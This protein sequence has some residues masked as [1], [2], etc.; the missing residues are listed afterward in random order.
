MIYKVRNGL[1]PIV[2]GYEFLN[3]LAFFEAKMPVEDILYDNETLFKR[4]I[5]RKQESDWTNAPHMD[6]SYDDNAQDIILRA[7]YK[8]SDYDKSV[9]NTYFMGYNKRNLVRE[10]IKMYLEDCPKRKLNY[11]IE[12]TQEEQEIAK[13]VSANLINYIWQSHIGH[14]IDSYRWPRQCK[15]I[16]KYLFEI[17]LAEIIGLD[18]IKDEMIELY[19][20]LSK[21]IAILY[22]N[23]KNLKINDRINGYLAYSNYELLKEGNEQY[24]NSSF[25]F[26]AYKRSVDIDVSKLSFAESH[27]IGGIYDW[28]EEPDIARTQEEIK[29]Q[30]VKKIVQSIE[31]NK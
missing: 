3:F 10:I 5:E 11:N 31:S 4:F 12:P 22:H 24:F 13:C 16:N 21:K 27:E 19:K 8:L 26:G 14:L 29:N 18:S 9:I 1:E 2:Y 6:I 23:D 30:K 17:D 28:D 20:D 25:G 7:N 15:D